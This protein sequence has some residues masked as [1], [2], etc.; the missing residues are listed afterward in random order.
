ML[1]PSRAAVL[2]SRSRR[3]AGAP[4][5]DDARAWGALGSLQETSSAME[6]GRNVR[7]ICFQTGRRGG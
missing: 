5:A 2:P 6:K 3:C 7:E 1:P 4:P